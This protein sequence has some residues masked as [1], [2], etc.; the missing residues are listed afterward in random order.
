MVKLGNAHLYLL[1]ASETAS[2]N[3]CTCPGDLGTL[4]YVVTSMVL[5]MPSKE[6]K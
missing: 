2:G 3:K 5:F 6:P 1:V 4:G